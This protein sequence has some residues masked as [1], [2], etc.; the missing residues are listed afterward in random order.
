M[1]QKNLKQKY[2]EEI[3]KTLK[4]EFKIKNDLSV[5]RVTKVVV[6]SGIGAATKDKSL[7]ETFAKDFAIITGQYPAVQKARVSVAS[8]NVRAGM[9]VGLRTTLRG[10]RMYAFLE[11]LFT[12]TL[13]RLRDFR[14]LPRKSFDKAG[15]Y[16]LG[17][18][19][20]TVFP[21][22]DLTK[23][24]RPFGLEIT[25]VTSTKDKEKAERLLELIGL[26]F[27]KKQ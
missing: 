24:V 2:Q 23:A 16:T 1:A 15:N 19:E 5:P 26:P 3:K 9:P 14:G 17:L 25:I 20:H 12:V 7:V 18:V 21:E 8:F 27:E 22:V 6:N 11:R 13:P 4:D 10:K